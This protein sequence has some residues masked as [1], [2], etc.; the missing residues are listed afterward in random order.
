VIW[1]AIRLSRNTVMVMLKQQRY[2]AEKARFV[3]LSC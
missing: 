1:T 2:L 3:D